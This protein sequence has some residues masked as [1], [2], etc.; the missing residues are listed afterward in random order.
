MAPTAAQAAATHDAEVDAKA[1]KRVSHFNAQ[2][3]SVRWHE[4]ITERLDLVPT[5]VKWAESKGHL[6]TV[7]DTARGQSIRIGG[8]LR[9][10][11]GLMTKATRD[12]IREAGFTPEQLAEI[13]ANAAKQKA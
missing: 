11:A 3:I 12:L 7:N 5:L 13:I 10:G 2:T 8:S 9:P 4:D 6:V 1:P